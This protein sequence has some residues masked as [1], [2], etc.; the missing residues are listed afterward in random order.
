[1]NTS[2][3]DPNEIHIHSTNPNIVLVAGD[4]GVHRSTD[5]GSTWTT[6]LNDPAYDIKAN[7]LN[8]DKL[9]LVMDSLGM[10]LLIS[11]YQLM[12]V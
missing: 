9:F 4:A 1:M 8:P 3:L 11:M 10:K 7:P 2:A 5:G 6:V 12:Q